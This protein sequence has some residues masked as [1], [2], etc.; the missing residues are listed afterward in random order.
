MPRATPSI[1]SP[2]S[3]PRMWTP[4]L[5]C[6]RRAKDGGGRSCSAAMGECVEL[7]MELG[8]GSTQQDMLAAWQ[9]IVAARSAF[10]SDAA[11][12]SVHERVDGLQRA[13]AGLLYDA[14]QAHTF[15]DAL[16]VCVLSLGAAHA[17]AGSAPP[18]AGAQAELSEL[19]LRVHTMLLETLACDS[20]PVRVCAYTRLHQILEEEASRSDG[21][22]MHCHMHGH[23]HCGMHC[24]SLLLLDCEV[25]YQLVLHGM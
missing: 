21:R 2:R 12:L 25:L 24:R 11:A 10:A 9:S 16:C 4:V 8:A 20:V 13:M 15:V 19:E 5:P 7:T 22:P 18:S 14:S 6:A 23:G 1:R 3:V 17:G